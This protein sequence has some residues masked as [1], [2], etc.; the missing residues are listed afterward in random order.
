MR[1]NLHT[2][3][4]SFAIRW[5]R[6]CR[7]TAEKT[8]LTITEKSRL[9]HGLKWNKQARSSWLRTLM[10]SNCCGLCLIPTSEHIQKLCSGTGLFSLIRC[11]S[12]GGT[13]TQHTIQI[14]RIPQTLTYQHN[15]VHHPQIP[16]ADFANTIATSVEKTS[17]NIVVN[18]EKFANAIVP[19]PPKASHEPAH[20]KADCVCACHACACACAC[21]SCACACAGGGGH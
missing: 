11:G 5:S 10:T 1:R 4:C 16:G 19:P 8:L 15:Q 7:V 21:V 6:N 18:I 9:K 13:A 3:S 14:P 12:G 17:N 2:P 20:P